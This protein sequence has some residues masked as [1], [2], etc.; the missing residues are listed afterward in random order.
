[1]TKAVSRNVLRPIFPARQEALTNS[2]VVTNEGSRSLQI[3]GD[4]MTDDATVLP[5][6][7]YKIDV[8]DVAGPVQLTFYDG[9]IQID[10]AAPMPVAPESHVE[11]GLLA[12]RAG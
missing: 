1:M 9:G 5:G 2:L 4:M 11:A 8:A 3:I 6:M 12:E 7:S 10:R